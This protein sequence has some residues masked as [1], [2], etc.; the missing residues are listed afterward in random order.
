M[1]FIN[2]ALRIFGFLIAL[3]VALPV[4]LIAVLQVPSGRAMISGMISSLVSTPDRQIAL[5]GLY[6]GFGLNAAV[7][8]VEIADRTGVWLT[9]EDIEAVWR[10]ARLISGDIDVTSIS[11][12]QIDLQRAPA[13]QPDADTAS[14][15]DAGNSEGWPLPFD[16]RV[17]QLT[18]EEINLGE[19]LLGAPVSLTASGSGSFALDPALI[20]ADLDVGRIDGVEAGLSAKAQFQPA[21]EELM[22]DIDISEPRGGL[23]ARLLEVPDL[24][25]LELTLKGD[26]PLTDWAAEL[27][28]ALDGRT[29]VTGS[30]EITETASGR[31]LTFDLDGDLATLAPPAA[32]AFVLGTTNASGSA[33]FSHDFEP[34][35]AEV[36]LRTRTVSLDARADL[37]DNAA[38]VSADLSVSAGDGAL[39]GVDIGERRIAFG[40]LDS[41]ISVSGKQDAADWSAR[42]DLASFQT[43]E[44]RTEAVRLTV[45]G[46]DAD[47]SPAA[48]TSPFALKLDIGHLEGLAPE[49][50]ALTGPVTLEGNGDL[51]AASETLHFR[52]LA[53]A[54][55]AVNLTLTEST[56]SPARVDG[57]GRIAVGDLAKFSGLA[58][59][60]L[61]G[62]VTG[63]LTADLDPEDLSGS[64]TAALITRDLATGSA[65]A[66]ALLTGETRVDATAALA[67]ANDISL[68]SLALD[69]E[70]LT[71]K[72]NGRYRDEGL[73]S[74]LTAQLQDLARVDPR[75][76]GSLAL[77][78]STA[79]PLS[80]LDVKA[81]AAS[82]QILLA[83]TPLDNLE[84][85]AQATADLAAPTARIEG[86]A[87]LNGQPLAVDVELTS[88]DGGAEINPLSIRLAGNSV[89]GTLAFADLENPVETLMGNLTI[90]A[91]DLGSLSPLLL[92]EISGRIEGTASADP[93]K[94]R[95]ALDITGADINLPSLSVGGLKLKANLAA[96]YAPE[97]VS[98]DVEITD[99]LTD[100]TPI[101]SVTLQARPDNG[102]TSIDGDMQLDGDSKDGLSL[103]AQVSEPESGT[104]L[105]NL[106]ELAMRYQG[107]S[108]RLIDPTTISYAQGV[109]T[110]EPLELQF[111]DGSLALA[112]KAGETLDLTAELKSVP[113]NLANAFV[114]SLGLGGTLSGKA[115]A[116][117][118][119]SDPQ[120]DWTIT[121]SDLTAAELRNNG[122]AAL[123][124]SSSGTLRNNQISQTTGI[125]DPNGLNLSSTGTVGLDQPNA[126]S[127]TLSGTVPAAVLRRP[128]LNA[129][130]RA[131]GAV[132]LNGTVG[133][134]T[135]SP[136]Y[137]IT[138]TPDGLKVTSLSTG[139]TVQNIRGTATVD[140]NQASIN[141]ITGDLATGGSLAASGT[142]G[143]TGDF[144]ANLALKLDKGRYID[145][146]LVSAEVDADLKVSG[147]LASTSSAALIDGKITINK[148]D[149]SIPEYLP[150]A[151]PP[152]DVH[153]VNA[154]AAIRQ[155]VA[156]LGGESGRAQTQQK[157][158]PPRL[159][160]LLSAPG[161]I[162]VRGRGLDAELQ[163]N[164]KIVGTTASPQAIG[165]FSLRR[166]QL[167][168]LTRRLV[169]SRGNA[170]FEGS[171]TPILDFA[172]TTSV[173]DTT[174][175]VTVSGEADDPQIAFSSSPD[176]PQDEVLALLLFGKNVGNLSA[177]QVA[178][179]AAAIA[180]LTGGSDSGP[181]ASIRK[182]LG[183]DAIDIN[184]EGDD[185]P[186]VAVGK[187]INDNIYVGVEQGTGSGSSRVKVDID[188]DRGLKVRGEVGADGSSKAGIF[189]EREY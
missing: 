99:L 45:S 63:T 33:R 81:E 182:S 178:R 157:S 134:T 41:K 55:E 131:D 69:N 95:L 160:I 123:G 57:Q 31:H 106:A 171:L 144:P 172:A 47:V 61:G 80:A 152:V 10:P 7:S 179:L 14:E 38:N 37:A 104:Y 51:D 15:Q 40:T 105:V 82:K 18:L 36:S 92:T 93:D 8:R 109:A 102:G 48:M 30:A 164:L 128:L 150:G 184:T 71:V 117:G 88:K 22:F 74:D 151:I 89:S 67:G 114:P 142:V 130:I 103:K 44:L 58:G 32:Q 161:Q 176:L 56:L 145:P 119:A 120:A 96:P 169:F 6:V 64:V 162:F 173:G 116:T 91:P 167:D 141:G 148:A 19:T 180:T 42:V 140:Q 186:S 9:A 118:S 1:R 26:G 73:T 121:G 108:S 175:T 12:G 39:I 72:G 76:S 181:L 122:L 101:H 11:A 107:V 68:T 83:G 21:A 24:P 77:E 149:V 5:E 158:V 43:R 147:P 189:F 13:P 85:S 125:R 70:Q 20:T 165:A 185:G 188:L 35:S 28:L 62:S 79:G 146:G 113:L 4:L 29:T 78:A 16:V 155:Q 52:E 170:T 133:G 34:N 127:L 139:L 100:A 159:D 50:A 187:Y 112:G 177:T 137:E 90:D 86:T 174:I 183:L 87:A 143:V 75:L 23:A 17:Q 60:D 98:A 53:L 163:G 66:D 132:A 126:L 156:E 49:T 3:A 27:S 84:L 59:R 138:A 115:S 2:L 136:V 94:K 166:G 110:I 65:Q 168:I 124:L 97:S 25:A 111:G 154:S 46:K 135:T 153:H 54:S 129:G